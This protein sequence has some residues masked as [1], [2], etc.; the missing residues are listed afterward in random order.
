MP[1]VCLCPIGRSQ[2]SWLHQEAQWEGPQREAVCELVS[3][4]PKQVLWEEP[5]G[6][7]RVSW[8]L[9]GQ[10]CLIAS[11][12]NGVEGAGNQGWRDNSNSLPRQSLSVLGG[13]VIHYPQPWCPSAHLPWT[14]LCALALPHYLTTHAEKCSCAPWSVSDQL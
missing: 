9:I 5:M 2:V 6:K 10:S 14:F 12:T 8:C 13:P 7:L 11:G 1:H 3:Y 4:W